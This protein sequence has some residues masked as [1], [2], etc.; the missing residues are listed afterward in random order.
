MT[1]SQSRATLAV[2]YIPIL[3]LGSL[4]SFAHAAAAPITIR[5]GPFA[6]PYSTPSKSSS[7]NEVSMG[8]TLVALCCKGGVVV[9]AD[10]RTSVSGF[11]SNRHAHKLTPLSDQIVVCRSGSAAD[12]QR[13]CDETRWELN[14][15]FMKQ[16]V[17]QV[18]HVA[19]LLRSY[20]VERDDLQASLLCAGVTSNGEGQLYA[21]LPSGA[22][23]QHDLFAVSGSGST[24]IMGYLDDQLEKGELL[25][26]Q[27]AIALVAKAIQL[28][29][30]RDASSGGFVR[31]Y[32][33]TSK[34]RRSITIY[35]S[36]QEEGSEE[37][38]EAAAPVR[39]LPGFA[40]RHDDRESKVTNERDSH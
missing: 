2:L 4:F 34:G 29:M 5:G 26:E 35:P 14:S 40:P 31:I 1:A 27:E 38:N 13:L 22:L 3:I 30:D 24:Y 16:R 10:T 37:S 23:F 9:G 33:I 36:H 7:K 32:S 6:N 17:L 20:M 28:A 19:K 21:I 15:L 25:S 8:T 11:V 12:T 39:D 18:S